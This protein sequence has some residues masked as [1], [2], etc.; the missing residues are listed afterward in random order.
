[1]GDDTDRDVDADDAALVVATLDRDQVKQLVKNGS[2]RLEY[3]GDIIA[4]S[5]TIEIEYDP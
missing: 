5:P 1:M 2:L 3:D 4:R